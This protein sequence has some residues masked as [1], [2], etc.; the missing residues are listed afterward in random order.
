MEKQK[1]LLEEIAFVT[2]LKMLAEAYEE[3]ATFKMRMARDS[4]LTNREFLTLLAQVFFNV[5]TSYRKQILQAQQHK[6]IAEI[7]HFTHASRNGKE[8]L[9]FFSANNKLY[10]DIIPR[11]FSLFLEK[12]RLN[13]QD[14]IAIVGESGKEMFISSGIDRK[15]S[16]FAI[17]DALTSYEMLEPLVAFLTKYEHVKAFYG[18]FA[19]IL[20]QEAVEE[21]ISGEEHVEGEDK[22]ETKD[23]AK[24][25]YF[26]PS[27]EKIVSFFETQVFALLLQQTVHETELARLASR[28]KAMEQAIEQTDTRLRVLGKAS[29]HIRH[30][31]NNKKQLEQLTKMYFYKRR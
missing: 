21:Y 23:K 15:Y 24:D 26:E 7:L 1:Q 9:I 14:D 10:G 4:V 31:I 11:I 8:V 5:R 25:F 12:V 28:I 30:D 18:K 27:I 2:G 20:T 6:S 19:N 29:I 22:E 17:P 16:Y 3:T 13:P